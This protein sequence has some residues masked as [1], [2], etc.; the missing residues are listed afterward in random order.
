MPTA[1]EILKSCE[2]D[3]PSFIEEAR[4]KQFRFK[5]R[6]GGPYTIEAVA[7]DSKTYGKCVSAY[8]VLK[9]EYFKIPLSQFENLNY[10]EQPKPIEQ[11]TEASQQRTQQG[12]GTLEK[13]MGGRNTVPVLTK[14]ESERI[15]RDE[16]IEPKK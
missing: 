6:A 9:D 4:G 3:I 1:L 12:T 13:L 2:G 15:L 8:D 7:E 10:E 16:G 5:K 14:E 11:P